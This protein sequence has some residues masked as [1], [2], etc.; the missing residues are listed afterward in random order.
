MKVFTKINIAPTL[1]FIVFLCTTEYMLI[2]TNRKKYDHFKKKREKAI[3]NTHK[4]HGRIW[5][6]L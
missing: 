2:N 5:R 4:R 1:I 6:F 3:K